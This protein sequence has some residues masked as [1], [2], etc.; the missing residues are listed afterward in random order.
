MRQLRP[1]FAGAL[2]HVYNRGIDGRDIFRDDRDRLF[3]LHWLARIV[4][5]F[6]WIVHV[7]TLMSNHF[8]LMIETPEANLSK[9]MQQ[10][11][12]NYVQMFNATSD[13]NAQSRSRKRR[14]RRGSLFEGRFKSQ[15]VEKESYLLE[16][17]RYIVLNPVRAGMVERPEEYRWSSYRAT[18]G[19]EAAPSWLTT[20]WILQQ[21]APSPAEALSAYRRFVD[22]GIGL[23]RSP[24]DDIK[25]QIYL[26]TAQWLERMRAWVEGEERSVEIPKTQR[27]IARPSIDE[28]IHTVAEVMDIEVSDIVEDRGGLPRMLVALLGFREGAIVLREI[29]KALTLRSSG[30]VSNLV[31]W[32]Q[33]RVTEQRDVARWFDECVGRLRPPA[34]ALS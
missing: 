29:A 19:L 9:G 14:R 21:F 17:S 15:L 11:L 32:C 26:G 5:K 4:E 28:V 3:F 25:H 13:G 12:T 18:A 8:H 31:R 20:S 10:L 23:A 7:Y 16:L 22:E 2:H 1:D 34:L 27:F 24:W 6:G 30:H 33:R